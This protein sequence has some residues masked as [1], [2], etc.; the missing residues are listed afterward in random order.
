M[1]QWILIVVLSLH[2]L[3]GIAWG[4][5]S[6][7]MARG[8][9]PLEA[10]VAVRPAQRGAAVTA[11][12]MG[13][14]L[15]GLAHRDR[16]YAAETALAVGAALAVLAAIVQGMAAGRLK[17]AMAAGLDEPSRKAILKLDRIGAVLL[18]LTV[19]LMAASKYL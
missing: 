11:M 5:M 12:L 15:W 6:L 3:A 8:L 16:F 1:M 17:G 18:A 13:L 2:I 9:M 14:I 7:G 10:S 19:I 4:G